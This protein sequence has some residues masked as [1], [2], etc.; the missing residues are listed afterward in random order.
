MGKSARL[1]SPAVR[2]LCSFP[3]MMRLRAAA[4]EPTPPN[5]R[6]SHVGQSVKYASQTCRVG[7]GAVAPEGP[8]PGGNVRDTGCCHERCH[9]QP[10]RPRS[11]E[12]G[13]EKTRCWQRVSSKPTPGLEPGT[14][15][16]RVKCSTS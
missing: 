4:N 14:P 13:H 6:A 12:R 10:I 9:R 2:R 7:K 5:T 11:A 1:A 16:L 15:S 3:W 8:D